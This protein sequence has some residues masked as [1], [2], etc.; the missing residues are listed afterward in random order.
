MWESQDLGD[1][2]RTWL[3]PAKRTDGSPSPR[4]HWSAGDTPKRVV[5]DPAVVEVVERREARRIRVSVKCGYGLRFDLTDALSRRLRKALAEAG[6]GATYA[7]ECDEA[8]VYAVARR[9]PLPQWMEEDGHAE[10][11]A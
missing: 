2:G 10:G 1:P 4:P 11:E 8:I 6:E 7:F 5:T 3:T 9:L